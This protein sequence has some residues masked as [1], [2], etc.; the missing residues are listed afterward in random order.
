MGYLGLFYGPKKGAILGVIGGLIL[1]V[2]L[3]IWL[4]EIFLNIIR[5]DYQQPKDTNKRKTIDFW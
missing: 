5:M 1:V 4:L 3:C 2:Y